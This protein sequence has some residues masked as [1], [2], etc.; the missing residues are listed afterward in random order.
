MR[1][2][3]FEQLQQFG[4]FLR[5][6]SASFLDQKIKRWKEVRAILSFD[7]LLSLTAEAVESKSD[8]GQSIRNTLR[9]SF[10]AALIDELGHRSCT[11]SYF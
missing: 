5:L 3:F 8:A 1:K 4:A 7:D 10:D 2:F 6:E 11:V 9:K